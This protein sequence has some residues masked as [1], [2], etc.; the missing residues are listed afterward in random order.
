MEHGDAAARGE[1]VEAD[2]EERRDADDTLRG[3]R[4]REPREDRVVGV[5][6]LHA[7]LTRADGE[8]VELIR[9]EEGPQGGRVLGERL[10]DAVGTLDEEPTV[11]LAKRACADARRPPS[12][13]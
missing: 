10:A 5:H 9:N 8:L 11:I 3:D 7:Y 2:I 1:R 13:S 6:D 4:G 12:D